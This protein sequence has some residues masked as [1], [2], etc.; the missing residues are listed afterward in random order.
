MLFGFLLWIV[1]SLG[2]MSKDRSK[3]AGFC[4]IRTLLCRYGH[5]DGKHCNVHQFRP[6][7]SSLQ[8]HYFPEIYLKNSIKF[9]W[10]F[11]FSRRCWILSITLHVKAPANALLHNDGIHLK[12]NKRIQISFDRSGDRMEKNDNSNKCWWIK[13]K[14]WQAEENIEEEEE[15]QGNAR[16]NNYTNA[17]TRLS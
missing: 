15:V 10:S 16:A 4:L 9:K 11:F 1:F 5:N 17:C 8:N 3:S 7:H 12:L 2:N 6:S 14:R 13:L